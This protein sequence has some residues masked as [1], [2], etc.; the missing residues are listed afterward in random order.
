MKMGTWSSWLTGTGYL[1][2][3]EFQADKETL[4]DYYRNHGYI[5]FEIKDVLFLNPT[6]DTLVIRFVVY[7]GQQ[8]KVGSVKFNV[9]S[10]RRMESRL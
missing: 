5:D 7:E 6:P 1:Q 9:K 2:D 8:Y 10:A 4:A 3:D